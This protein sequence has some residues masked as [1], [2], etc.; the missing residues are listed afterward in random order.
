MGSQQTHRIP[1]L[2]QAV[3]W[4]WE[5]G[6]AGGGSSRARLATRALTAA[7]RHP[8]IMSRWLTVAFELQSR[9]VIHDLRGE[10]LRAIRPYV[11]NRTSFTDRVV[12]LI[13]HMDWLETAFKRAAFE[14]VVSGEPLVLCELTVPRGYDFLRLQLQHAPA[15]SPEGEMLLTLNVRRS[16]DV[17]QKTQEVEVAALAFSRFRIDDQACLVIGG[18]RGQ[19]HPVQRISAMEVSQALQGWKPSVLLVRVAQE[20]A[21]YWNLH[22]VGL[23]PAAHRLHG[24]SYRWNKRRRESGQRV[25]ASYDALWDHFD[26]KPG[27]S[28]WV[29]I[30]LNSDEKL[31]ATA[32]S[33]E[34]RARQTRRAD[35]WIRTRNVMRVEFKKLLEKPHREPRFS[36][37]TE[38][39]DRE[40]MRARLDYPDAED[41][42][43][44]DETE[45]VVPSR[46]LETGPGN[47]I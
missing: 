37:I 27:P 32:L 34:K 20:L 25:F 31:A 16:A 10:Y 18:V 1:G 40:S 41:Y 23:D 30:P 35:Y 17:Q 4:A 39:M 36:R 45:D 44:S 14:Q 47:L 28:G 8:R 29:V 9:G 13:D 12:H 2:W 11:H 26:S 21:R 24:W 5:P 38:T 33:P 15:Q 3:R 42:E 46:V 19:R 43:D 7:L 6:A 22:L